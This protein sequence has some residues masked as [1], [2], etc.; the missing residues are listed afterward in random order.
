MQL[1]ENPLQEQLF[2]IKYIDKTQINQK[3]FNESK[4]L[5]TTQQM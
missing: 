4:P 2:E 5:R 1:T 3:V